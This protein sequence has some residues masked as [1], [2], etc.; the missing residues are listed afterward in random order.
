MVDPR[1]FINK[2]KDNIKN[3]KEKN[4]GKSDISQ[5]IHKKNNYDTDP[6][7]NSQIGK[8][9]QPLEF[10]KKKKN[11]TRILIYIQ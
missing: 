5:N 3:L 11:T 1:E 2:K 6:D 4:L 9:I 8:S 7:I 10:T